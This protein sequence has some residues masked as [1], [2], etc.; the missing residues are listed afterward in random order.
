[1]LKFQ[2]YSMPHMLLFLTSLLERGIVDTSA[3]CWI[4][5]DSQAKQNITVNA[6]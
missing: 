3:R 2:L 6:S 5:R 1:M 4:G